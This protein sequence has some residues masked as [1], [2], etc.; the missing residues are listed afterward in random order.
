MDMT[1]IIGKLYQTIFGMKTTPAVLNFISNLSW[2]MVGIILSKAFIMIISL[3]GGR[4]LGPS[5]FG[6]YQVIYSVSLIMVFPMLMGANTALIK[7]VSPLKDKNDIKRYI[8]STLLLFLIFALGGV[9]L[10]SLIS[11]P[12]SR[13]LSLSI[14]F[15][16]LAVLFAVGLGT[17]YFGQALL[18]A[19]GRMKLFSILEIVAAFFAFALF[20]YLV[21]KAGNYF[22]FYIPVLASFVIFSILA[23][24]HNLSYFTNL[25]ADKKTFS[26]VKHYGFFGMLLALSA[27]VLG[28]ADKIIM[29]IFLDPAKVGVFQAYSAGSL[30]AISIITSIFIT[31]FFPTASKYT[32]KTSILERL[33]RLAI[34]ATVLILVVIPVVQ[35]IALKIFGSEYYLNWNLV[36]GFA[37][38]S[39]IYFLNLSYLWL[40]SSVGIP[41]IKKAA[42]SLSVAAV[43]NIVLNILLIQKK[44]LFGVLIALIIAWLIPL[45]YIR[46]KLPGELRKHIKETQTYENPSM[47]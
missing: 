11:I 47:Y 41:G 10:Y 44:D 25:K 5:E 16:F 42:I 20:S 46:I 27:T 3:L 33:D 35:W 40:I 26:I 28:N 1:K 13:I 9:I 2:V 43:V 7:Y 29:N 21:S 38:A 39:A 31:V 45:I 4:L 32:D 19:L 22:A 36:A 17:Y 24:M 15:Y 37:V 30:I 6:K 23:L 14:E 8:G 12:I 18:Q 34:P